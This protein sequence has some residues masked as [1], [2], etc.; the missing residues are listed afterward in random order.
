M[1]ERSQQLLAR[2]VLVVIAVLLVWWPKLLLVVFILAM[3]L[4]LFA[5][6]TLKI[7]LGVFCIVGGLLGEVGAPWQLAM[8]VGLAAAVAANVF[9][10]WQ[11]FMNVPA[12]F[13]RLYA[14]LYS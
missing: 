13:G 3:I 14:L 11:T 8:P 12:M 7:G 5:L 2:T 9:V 4:G 1:T 10:F 6:M